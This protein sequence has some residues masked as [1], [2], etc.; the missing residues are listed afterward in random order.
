M[1]VPLKVWHVHELDR[2]YKPQGSFK[3]NLTKKDTC[4]ENQKEIVKITGIYNE[5]IEN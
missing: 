3:E 4:P 2:T 1:M 5:K